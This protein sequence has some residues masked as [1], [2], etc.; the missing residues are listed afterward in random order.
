VKIDH[1]FAE[2]RRRNVFKVAVAY[3]IA[4]WALAQGIAQVF[5]VFDV[6]NWV[7]RLLVLLIMIGFPIALVMAWA[8]ELT[9]E[10]LKR[11]AVA[12]AMPATDSHIKHTWIY[13]AVIGALLSIGLFS[14]GRYTAVST[15]SAATDNTAK[16]I[17]V[18]PFENR[19]DDKENSYFAEGVQD[20]ILTNLAKVSEL[21]V[22]S[23]ISAR[24]Y[25]S[26]AQRNVREIGRQLGVAYVLEGSVQRSRDHLQI[27][28]HLIDTRTDTHI[29]DETYDRPAEDLFTIQSELAQAIVTQL[30]TKLSPE[31]QAEIVDWET[32][33]FLAR[34]SYFQAKQIVDSYLVAEDVRAALLKALELL[35]QAITRDEKFVSAYCYAARAN[36]LLYFFDLDPIPD[37]IILAETAVNTALRLRPKSAE[38]HFTKAD[39]LFRCRRDYDGALAELAIARKG[40]PNNTA[41][42]ILSGYV[43]RRRN[44]WPEAERDFSMAVAHDPR[45]ANAYNLLADTYVLKRRFSEAVQTYDQV[46]A[47]GEQTPLVQ[48][49]RAGN[50]FNASGDTKPLRDVVAKW[51][52]LDVAGGQTPVR[53]MF[54]LIDGDH[55]KAEHF[56]SASPRSDFQEIDFSFYYPKAWFE[57]V[58]A[59]DGGDSAKALA[60]FRTARA[61]LA[62][63]LVVKPEHA[64]TIAVLAQ[65]DAALGDT[66]LALQEAQHAIEL[67]PI[68]KDIYDGAL[69][70]EG[71]AQVYTWTNQPAKAIEVLRKLVSMP[72]YTN[73]GRLKL[74]PLWKPLRGNPDFEKIITELG[75]RPISSSLTSSSE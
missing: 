22:I 67:M 42:F 73:Y 19:G 1:F 23:N 27:S 64:R 9:P 41:F 34:D 59:R 50:F 58:I 60:A 74:H 24:Q 3:V 63:R 72:G 68:S 37:R 57:A 65:V 61:V 2:L 62:Q 31:Q 49:R 26:G 55:A 54:A 16:S 7:I 13:V 29:W 25:K 33:N 32:Q 36:D 17:A 20:Q 45:N 71:L 10:G 52:D 51:P 18:L 44:H 11:T 38:A 43:N 66:E 12:D 48:F 15:Q 6:P 75:P 46:M 8:F 69:V 4:G 35:D 28:A 40:L 47:A 5:P 39:F 21:K 53:V 30:N 70:L 14:L 56:L